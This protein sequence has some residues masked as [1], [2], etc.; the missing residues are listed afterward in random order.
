M[1]LL[2]RNVGFLCH[3]YLYGSQIHS[4]LRVI[5]A[6]NIVMKGGKDGDGSSSSSG[7]KMNRSK[8]IEGKQYRSY[9]I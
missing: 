7:I 5:T 8:E 1:A 2:S 4:S 3:K 9:H 6:R